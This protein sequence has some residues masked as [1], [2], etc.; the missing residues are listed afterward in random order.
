[1]LRTTITGPLAEMTPEP[2]STSTAGGGRGRCSPCGRPARETWIAVTF[3]SLPTGE[4]YLHFGVRATPKMAVHSA[5]SAATRRAGDDRRHIERSSVRVAVRGPRGGPPAREVAA[6]GAELLGVAPE[7]SS[8]TAAPTCAGGSATPTRVLLLAHHDTVWP[9]G[10]SRRIRSSVRDGVLRGPGLL[11][12]EG[13]AGAGAARA[14]RAAR[15]RRGDAAGHRGR[16]ARVADVARADRGGGG[17]APRGARARGVRRRRRAQDRAQGR[18]AV[19]GAGQGRAAHAGLEPE[20]GVN[21]TVELAHQVLAVA[22][23]GRRRARHDRDAD[24]V[25]AG[26]TTNTVPAAGAFV[27][28]RA[29][30][31]IAEQDRVDAAMRALLPG[32]PRR[33]ARGRRRAEPAAAGGRR[34]R[35]RCSPARRRSPPA[36]AAA[37][38]RRAV[39]GASDG[40]FTAGVGTP[41]LDGLGAVGGGAHADDEH[42]ARR[43]ARAAGGAARRA[44]RRSARAGGLMTGIDLTTGRRRRSPAAVRCA[45]SGRGHRPG[46]RRID[47]LRRCVACSTRSGAGPATR[48]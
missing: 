36:R 47:E 32:A 22:G 43:R 45:P 23:A 46:A 18:V 37:A 40:N 48:R 17:A 12:H 6:V 15:P 16:G 35:R 7:R 44:D 14:R 3:Y 27:R 11:R 42:V 39:G 9:S 30:V 24:R 41:T 21:A 8:S 31:D 20:R 10:R 38:R 2:L 34:H 13:R 19:R 5:L 33:G 4:R 28:R 29:G 1:M 25:V 26:T